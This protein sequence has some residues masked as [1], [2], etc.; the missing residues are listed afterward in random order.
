MHAFFKQ[1]IFA[2]LILISV[3]LGAASPQPHKTIC[4]NMIVKDESEVITRCLSSTLPV[5]DYWVIV[6]TGSTDG[7]Q[8]IIKNYMKEKGVPGELHE[9]PWKN[10]AHNR[11]EALE[12]AKG[13]A[14][15]VFFI[16]ADEYMTYDDDFELPELS[17]DYY[18][19][20][21]SYA[22][23]LYDRI[24]LVGNHL[25]WKYEGVLHEAIA[26]PYTASFGRIEKMKNVVTTEGARSKDPEK[27]LKDAK[28]LESALLDEP[29]NAR[30]TYYLAQSYRDAGQHEKALKIYEK[31]ISM[32]GWDQET[33][34]AMLDAARMQETLGMPEE[35]IITGYSRAFQFRPSRK[36]PLYYLSNYYRRHGKYDAGFQISKIAMSIPTS[37]DALFVQTWMDDYGIPLENSI[38][39]YWKND[40][41][42][43][44][45]VSQQILSKKDLPE[46][47]KTCV[48]NNLGFANAKIVEKICEKNETP[49]DTSK[50]TQAMG[51]LNEKAA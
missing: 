17:K 13:K 27:Y 45:K 44:K 5:I 33:F 15:Y 14:D 21:I 24:K 46:D 51:N 26:P 7:T 9:R 47:I 25:D 22:G 3:Q 38:C 43:C 36:E 16:D 39:A 32:G 42:E 40:F 10:F 48:E 28:L 18:Y 34:I 50:E 23:T 41:E 30:Y 4:L 37:K 2:T 49:K 8:Q 12:F 20:T 31:R 35:I 19:G 11:N 29:N 1:F 6:D